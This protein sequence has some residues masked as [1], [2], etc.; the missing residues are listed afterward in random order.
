[1]F[2]N[3]KKEEL[4]TELVVKNSLI[5]DLLFE[6]KITLVMLC[7]LLLNPISNMLITNKNSLLYLLMNNIFLIPLVY[8]LYLYIPKKNIN[9]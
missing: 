8:L 3:K 4:Q 1:M 9:N 2:W 5:N 6:R 7:F